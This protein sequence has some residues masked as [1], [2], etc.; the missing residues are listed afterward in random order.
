LAPTLDAYFGEAVIWAGQIFKARF[1][2]D[3]YEV[4]LPGTEAGLGVSETW[5]YVDRRAILGP[6]R[7]TVGDVLTV[8]GTAWEVVG[9]GEDDLGEMQFRL[10]K[11]GGDEAVAA[12]DAPENDVVADPGERLRQPGRSSRRADIVSAFTALAEGGIDTSRPMTEI[13]PA[14]RQRITG[15]AAPSSG[16]GDKTLRKTLAPLFEGRRN[17][18]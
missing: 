3:P 15:S 16:L 7:P 4:S 5:L 2:S 17:R 13:F 18:P 14:V 12:T 8:R 1:R 6:R 10:I 11:Y 9:W